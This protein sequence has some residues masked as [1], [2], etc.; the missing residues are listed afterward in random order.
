MRKNVHF[1]ILKIYFIYYII[2]LYNS[3]NILF[4]HLTIQILFFLSIFYYLLERV[5]EE[6]EK[7]NKIKVNNCLLEERDNKI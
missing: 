1:I 6:K 2:L 5:C 3:F 7:S 4:F